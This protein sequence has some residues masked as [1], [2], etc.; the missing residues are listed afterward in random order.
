VWR[1]VAKASSDRR[2]A[3]YQTDQFSKAKMFINPAKDGSVT[4]T[5]PLG[6]AFVIDVAHGGTAYVRELILHPAAAPQDSDRKDQAD[7]DAASK[8]PTWY[9]DA[10]QLETLF[11]K[12]MITREEAAE[13]KEPKLP[14]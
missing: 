7:G 4:L 3:L 11:K 13:L 2:A 8:A 12:R 14:E 9:L 1:F 10:K 6:A 5:A